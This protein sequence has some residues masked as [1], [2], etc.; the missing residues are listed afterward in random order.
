ML[1]QALLDRC[2]HLKDQRVTR[3]AASSGAFS[4]LG[5]LDRLDCRRIGFDAYQKTDSPI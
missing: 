5:M 2:T 1:G 4:V 3:L